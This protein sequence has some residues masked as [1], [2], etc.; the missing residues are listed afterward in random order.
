MSIVLCYGR[1]VSK[2][3]WQ[4]TVIARPPG[5]SYKTNKDTKP[6][7][8]GDRVMLIVPVQKDGHKEIDVPGSAYNSQESTRRSKRA[9]ILG[10]YHRG[11]GWVESLRLDIALESPLKIRTFWWLYPR[12]WQ[13][14]RDVGFYGIDQASCVVVAILVPSERGLVK[15]SVRFEFHF[16]GSPHVKWHLPNV[17]VTADG[18]AHGSFRDLFVCNCGLIICYRSDEVGSSRWLI[19]VFQALSSANWYGEFRVRHGHHYILEDWIWNSYVLDP[20]F[21]ISLRSWWPNI[22]FNVM[23]RADQSKYWSSCWICGWRC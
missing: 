18:F 14:H 8:R 13:V 10:T 19:T 9:E 5:S 11:R 2:R 17:Q 1:N 6:G 16:F 7:V 21:I 12:K 23:R 4:S 20:T 15:R 3:E 22:I